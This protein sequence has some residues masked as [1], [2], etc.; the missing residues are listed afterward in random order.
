[1]R[2]LALK[3]QRFLAAFKECLNAVGG[4]NY[5]PPNIL[6]AFNQRSENT[7]RVLKHSS[8]KFTKSDQRNHHLFVH[9]GD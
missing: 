9:L 3:S 1:M 6:T 8:L 7:Q 2:L 4:L 5:C